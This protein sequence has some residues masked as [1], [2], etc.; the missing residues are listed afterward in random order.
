MTTTMR[1]LRRRDSS[2]RFGL[3]WPYS[4]TLIPS[5]TIAARNPDVLD[6]VAD[7]LGAGGVVALVCLLRYVVAAVAKRR[8]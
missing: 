3:F 6:V 2:M 8:L 4:R 1:K 5:A 7:T